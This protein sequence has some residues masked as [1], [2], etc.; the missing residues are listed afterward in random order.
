VSAL[1][2][3]GAAASTRPHAAASKSAAKSSPLYDPAG[4]NGVH[5]SELIQISDRVSSAISAKSL[6]GT[7]LDTHAGKLDV[8]VAGTSASAFATATATMPA[9]QRGLIRVHHVPLGLTALNA[10][11]NRTG[12]KV[13]GLVSRKVPVQSWWADF[14]TGK[15]VVSLYK[16]TSAQRRLAD[17]SMGSL[18]HQIT[19]TS[20]KIIPIP[21]VSR[22]VAA[23]KAPIPAAAQ[24]SRGFDHSPFLGGDFIGHLMGSSIA[25]C[26]DSW[27]ISIG[28]K[29]YI[30]TAGHCGNNGASWRNTTLNK[31][32]QLVGSQKHVGT[33]IRNDLHTTKHL[34]AQLLPTGNM[35]DIWSGKV[36]NNNLVHVTAHLI[37]PAGTK[38]CDDGAYEGNVCGAVLSKSHYN[39]CVQSP[40][41]QMCHL[42]QASLPKGHVLIGQGDSGGPDIVVAGTSNGKITKAKAIGLNSLETAVNLPCHLFTWR[43]NVCS[44]TMLYTGVVA[45]LKAYGATLRTSS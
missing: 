17:R 7:A 5:Q 14:T 13:Q 25:L 32:S 22:N 37:P 2:A 12:T 16:P 3:I 33:A 36:F 9:A 6:A 34:D 20:V 38:V 31:N 10:N 21:A 43:G 27:P 11:M 15:I 23:S 26:T 30:T 40:D 35:P 44:N 18:P 29:H 4:I 24:R 1:T 39:G 45:I 28:S 42:F 19:T 8:Y 41:G